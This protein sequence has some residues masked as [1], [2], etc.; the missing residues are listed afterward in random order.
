MVIVSGNT[1]ALLHYSR[2]QYIHTVVPRETTG[3]GRYP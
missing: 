3:G 1:L 2:V